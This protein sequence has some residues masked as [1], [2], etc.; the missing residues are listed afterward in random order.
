[1]SSTPPPQTQLR[2]CAGRLRVRNWP[3]A[4]RPPFGLQ[5]DGGE[6]EGPAR[7]RW[8][9]RSKLEAEGCAFADD[10]TAPPAI[11]P[12]P[13]TPP[14]AS[15]RSLHQAGYRGLC[16]GYG[17][18][19]RRALVE[20]LATQLQCRP[21]IAVVDSAAECRWP[22]ASRITQLAREMHWRGRQHGLL[23]VDAPELMPPP[24]LQT[25]CDA[26]AALY[27]I[28]FCAEPETNTIAR[29]APLLGPVLALRHREYEIEHI[30]LRVPLPD[31]E[32]R[33]YEAAWHRFLCAYDRFVKARGHGGFGSFVQQV[34]GD[35]K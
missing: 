16:I 23:C 22:E 18:S 33:R 28:G 24:L 21:L 15:L 19:D 7:L 8:Q 2:F 5:R 11:A 17:E 30:E 10:I 20:A 26:S 3:E 12:P 25:A 14:T 13:T 35:S 34:R 6:F 9:V 29:C 31:D 27:R 1:M 32:R 4:L